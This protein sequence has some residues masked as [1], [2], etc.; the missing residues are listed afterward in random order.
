MVYPI[1]MQ[2]DKKST[3]FFV[4]ALLGI[5]FGGTVFTYVFLVA[6]TGANASVSQEV[7]FS[8]IIGTVAATPACVSSAVPANASCAGDGTAWVT[9][10]WSAGSQ[11]VSGCAS[12]G[13]VYAGYG[14]YPSPYWLSGVLSIRI[15]TLSGADRRVLSDQNCNG[16]YTFSG[17]LPGQTY[18]YA[19]YGFSMEEASVHVDGS[20]WIPSTG[21]FTTPN[22]LPPPPP[23]QCSDGI[24]NADPE[25]SLIDL[26]DPG[27]TSASDTDET[28]A[29]ITQCSDGIDN[30][31]PEDSLIDLAD[32]GC[33]SASDTDETNS[34]A[35]PPSLTA[36]NRI[37]VEGST[38]TLIWNT[39]GNDPALCTLTGGTLNM[40]PLSLS[41]G[42]V[43]TV[44]NAYTMY[45]LTCPA[46]TDTVTVEIVPIGFET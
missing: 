30:A 20:D 22:C 23:S 28:N 3:L 36:S 34:L 29:P 21:T 25:D 24:D 46:G 19:F 7:N 8:D 27:C 14:Y 13:D 41:T 42:S 1:A 2:R 33:T 11:Y 17:L 31:D 40:S 18:S 12:T 45:T 26:A 6:G 39:T 10:S 16:S 44:V 5:I 43:S 32:P 4:L 38:V 37:V 35:G 15:S 9:F